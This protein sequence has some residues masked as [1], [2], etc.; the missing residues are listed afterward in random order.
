MQTRNP[1]SPPFLHCMQRNG[2]GYFFSFSL[3]FFR[4]INLL[5]L[6]PQ[7]QKKVLFL[8]H[9]LRYPSHFGSTV[10]LSLVV[11]VV[12]QA[13]LFPISILSGAIH[14]ARPPPWHIGEILKRSAL[15]LSQIWG[16]REIIFTI[17]ERQESP[18]TAMQ[19][20]RVSNKT[21]LQLCFY[22]GKT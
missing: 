7:L 4:A 12:L 20:N 1:D 8:G 14:Y 22:L 15:S 10:V 3:V 18:F 17:W 2:G 16:A 6:P 19:R 5:F 11:G 21:F 13:L 9:S